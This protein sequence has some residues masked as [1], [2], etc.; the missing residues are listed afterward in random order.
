MVVFCDIASLVVVDS[1][2]YVIGAVNPNNNEV[3]TQPYA[4]QSKLHH[5]PKGLFRLKILIKKQGIIFSSANG[6]VVEP[7]MTV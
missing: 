1:E 6:K 4:L 2:I 5:F 3:T 7:R